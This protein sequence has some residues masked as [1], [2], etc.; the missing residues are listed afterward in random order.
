MPLFFFISGYLH[1]IKL[2]LKAFWRKKSIHLLIPYCSFLLLLYPLQLIRAARH[3]HQAGHPF[4]HAVFAGFW[5]GGELRGPYG[6]FWFLP[7]L[8][9]TQQLFNVFLVRYRLVVV[10]C[11]VLAALALSYCEARY[12]PGF[13]LPLDAHVAL[14]ALPF[15]L[16]GYLSN[17]HQLFSKAWI[18][19][20]VFPGVLIGIWLER[21]STPLFYD[22]RDAVYGVPGITL[23]LAL[24]F[25]WMAVGISKLA[26]ATPSL[27]AL[28]VPVGEASMGIMFI[29]KQLTIIPAVY[30]W[31]DR[32]GYVASLVFTTVSLMITLLL[33]RNSAS[34]ALLLGSEEDFNR[35]FGIGSTRQKEQ[36]AA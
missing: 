31:S 16:F 28:F 32:H 1:T 20:L 12:L 29:H 10:E 9:I 36:A 14:A 33:K 8:F 18:F 30:S 4:A 5:G 7:C 23:V 25:I 24:C 19:P 34:R 26:S 3:F 11:L 35:L 6:V 21:L 15:F 2:D 22:M 13:S 27:R 17:K